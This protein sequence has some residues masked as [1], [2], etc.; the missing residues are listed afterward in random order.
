V[1]K[2]SIQDICEKRLR[3]HREQVAIGPEVKQSEGLLR[4]D[5]DE[6]DRAR[7]RRSENVTRLNNLNV[8]DGHIDPKQNYSD[9]GGLFVP[10][11]GNDLY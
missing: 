6:G 1:F 4:R 11:V 8:A 7:R 10:V 2:R 3:F 9:T 5:P